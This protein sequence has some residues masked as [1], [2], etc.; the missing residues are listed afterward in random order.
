MYK[1]TLGVDKISFQAKKYNT[2]NPVGSPQVSLMGGL[3][4][5]GLV[6]GIFI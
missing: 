1:D 4:N 5:K 3:D 6:K 2:N